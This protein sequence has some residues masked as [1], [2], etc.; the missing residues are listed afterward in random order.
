MLSAAIFVVPVF[1]IQSRINLNHEY[2]YL[3]DSHT[4]LL[5]TAR[6]EVPAGNLLYLVQARAQAL[7]RADRLARALECGVP[8]QQGHSGVSLLNKRYKNVIQP[9]HIS[10]FI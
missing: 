4:M 2:T 7:V 5:H 6:H 10:S 8:A 3:P 9:N 1:F